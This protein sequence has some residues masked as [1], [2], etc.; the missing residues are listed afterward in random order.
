M[1]VKRE[2]HEIKKNP[3]ISGTSGFSKKTQKLFGNGALEC[4]V[5]SLV[6]KFCQFGTIGVNS[7]DSIT[8]L[9]ALGGFLFENNLCAF[10]ICDFDICSLLNVVEL[11]D[12]LPLFDGF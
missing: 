1:K 12:I 2:M 8:K 3:D 11:H 5:G 9:F 4:V 6:D 7:F 10:G